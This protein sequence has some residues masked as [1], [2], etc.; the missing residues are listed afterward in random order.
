MKKTALTKSESEVMYL[1]WH[2]DRA[3]SA[4]EMV[5]GV[6]PVNLIV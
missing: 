5:S 3:L 1:L 2:T 4:A 6:D